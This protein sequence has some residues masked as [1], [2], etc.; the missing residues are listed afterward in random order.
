MLC[1]MSGTA[2]QTMTTQSRHTKTPLPES[3]MIYWG[4]NQT[5]SSDLNGLLSNIDW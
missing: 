1:K 2:H 4:R 5:F 3:Q